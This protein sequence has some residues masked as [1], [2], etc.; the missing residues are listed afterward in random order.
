MASS[1]D[2]LNR[3]AADPEFLKMS[4]EDQKAVLTHITSSGSSPSATPTPQG[5]GMDLGE[6]AG[7]QGTYD[8][9]NVD[10]FIDVARPY[11]AGGLA[12]VAATASAPIPIPGSSI[13]SYGGAYTLADT[14]MQYL[15]E[16]KPESLGGALKE[17][18]VN[19]GV[20]KVTGG[21]VKAGG[22]VVKAFHGADQPEI[23]NFSPTTS[24]A[25]EAT[26]RG[27]LAAAAKYFEDI[28]T[29]G[30]NK[31]LDRTAGAGFS[32]A[33]DFIGEDDLGERRLSNLANDYLPQTTPVKFVGNPRTST[34]IKF[35]EKEVTPSNPVSGQ[36]EVLPGETKNLP[37]T[38]FSTVRGT[39]GPTDPIDKV[40]ADPALLEKTLTNAQELG[41]GPNLRKT[42]GNYQF[43]KVF[44][45]GAEYNA[46]GGVR[47]INSSA[48][49]QML[50]D[51]NM[52]DSY[53][54]LWGS[55]GFSNVK[56]FFKNISYTQD[57]VGA[58]TY[59]KLWLMEGGIGMASGLL[60]TGSPLVGSIGGASAA[61]GGYL[62]AK[63]LGTLLNK[64]ETARIMVNLASGSSLGVPDQYANRVILKALQGMT[65]AIMN[66]D[67]SK[68]PVKVTDKGLEP[69]R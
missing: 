12:D 13:A 67:G 20:Q 4:P 50:G 51:P 61:V 64:P 53:K 28:A 33:L 35:I 10:T 56:Q 18:L 26:G 62:S 27:K 5:K 22:R 42:L 9:K 2:A 32:R 69:L 52:Q 14:L 1:T 58:G 49:E 48:I 47:R 40:L 59:R 7:M 8:R 15:K 25:L 54:K 41:T 36:T 44:N 66:E 34:P 65:I 17:G 21:L 68:T 31:A 19:A 16:K 60:L 43:A 57:K 30:K 46:E 24:Q 45:S 38:S 37:P 6:A 63:A 3:I 39:P 11:V 29:S 55:E 23:M